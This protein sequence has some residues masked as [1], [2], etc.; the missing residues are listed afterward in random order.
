ML[1]S[2]NTEERLELAHDGILVGICFDANLTSLSVLDEPG[3]ATT[4]DPCQCSVELLLHFVQVAVCVVN[5]LGQPARWGVTTTL[6]LGCEVLPEQ[7]VVAMPTSMKVDQRLESNLG[8]DV[9]V[10][11]SSGVLVSG[12]VVGVDVGLMV[13][14]VVKL[15]SLLVLS[16]PC[17]YK[18][19][20]T[21]IILP[22]IAGSRAP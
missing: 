14:G 13:L 8:T 2:I 21:S 10:C 19:K 22:L 1:P 5:G 20:P 11:L 12:I 17:S 3:P 15:N 7:G 9:I 6:V 18:C 4:L 16:R